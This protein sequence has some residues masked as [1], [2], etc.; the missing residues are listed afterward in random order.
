MPA[1]SI[2]PDPGTSR[3][4]RRRRALL[5]GALRVI[6]RD[7]IRA[8]THRSVAAEAGV[9]LG[10]TTYYFSSKD[11]LIEACL[12]HAAAREVEGIEERL[13]GADPAAMAP[14]AWAAAVADWLGEAL[15]GD[16]R[17]ALVARYQLQLEA[18]HRPALREVYDEWTRSVFRLAERMLA[19]AGSPRPAVD[20]AIVLAAVD[21]MRLN[22][23]ARAEGGGAVGS[24][25]P[26][27]ERL[28]DRLLA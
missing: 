5:E 14:A 22:Q 28:M 18:A 9:P 13:A 21:G 16:A 6:G 26:A 2:A 4:E 19:A 23:L 24:L 1:P 17:L 20:A 25:R 10:A 3:G 7:G 27:L 15:E 8:V 11:A 12:R